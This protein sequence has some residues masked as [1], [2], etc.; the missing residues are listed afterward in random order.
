[1]LDNKNKLSVYRIEAAKEKLD[2]ASLLLQENKY[3]DCV[4]RSYYAIFNAIRS[5][6]ALE[7]IDYKKHSAVISHFRQQYI[8]T[9]VFDKEL[10]IIVGNAFQVRNQSDYEDFFMV[11]KEEAKEQ[12]ENAKKFITEIEVYLKKNSIV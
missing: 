3:K 4:N 11:S 1:M 2:S 7:G 8:K 5:L 9:G 12:C 10:S 6:L